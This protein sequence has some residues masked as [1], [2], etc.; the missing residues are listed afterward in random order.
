MSRGASSRRVAVVGNGIIGHGIA[1]VFAR[2]GWNATLIGRSEPSLAGALKRIR[3]SLDLFVESDLLSTSEAEEALSRICTTIALDDAAAAELV[4]EAVPEDMELKLAIFERLDALCGAQTILATSSGHPASAV[5]RRTR[6][7]A[8]VVATHFWYP[9]QLLPLVEVCGSPATAPD[10][11]ERACEILRGVGKEPVV[12]AR[13]VP[14]FIGNRIQFAALREAWSLW[15]SGAASAEAIDSVVRHSIGRRLGVTGP[16]ESAD[17]G[18]LDTMF[19]FA[20]FLQPLLNADPEPPAQIGALVAEGCRG[21]PSGR[22]VYDWSQRDGAELLAE[23]KRELVRW[24]KADQAA[25][26]SAASPRRHVAQA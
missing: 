18:G 10:V 8:R 17:L 26:E 15:S 22:G 16:I 12:I 9:P 13:E 5:D 1:E 21:V 4:I 2:G 11:V 23:R 14:G 24:L 19:H 6:R 7:K 20:S 3:E 25:R